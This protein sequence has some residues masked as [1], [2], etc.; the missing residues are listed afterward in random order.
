MLRNPTL[1]R[2]SSQDFRIT[3]IIRNTDVYAIKISVL[4]IKGKNADHHFS[5]TVKNNNVLHLVKEN[6][7]G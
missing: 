7:W 4:A 6:K 2:L 5:P 1:E 3:K